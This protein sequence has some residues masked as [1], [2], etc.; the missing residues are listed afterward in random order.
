MSSLKGKQN[1]QPRSHK[2]SIRPENYSRCL[3]SCKISKYSFI[4]DTRPTPN[5]LSNSPVDVFDWF[6]ITDR[7][8]KFRIYKL[9]EDRTTK[10]QRNEV[11][12]PPLAIMISTSAEIYVSFDYSC[13]AIPT[14]A[15][16]ILI[17]KYDLFRKILTFQRYQKM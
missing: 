15:M 8:L 2:P 5:G 4:H 17:T 13:I 9:L 12:I 3:L 10:N 1:P 11:I 7:A 16:K 14:V 6:H